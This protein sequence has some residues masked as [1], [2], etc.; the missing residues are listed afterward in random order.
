MCNKTIS[1]YQFMRYFPNEDIAIKYLEKRHWKDGVNCP[2]CCGNRIKKLRQKSYYL[3][4]DC[5]KKFTVRTGTIFARSH[6][7]LDKWLY[8]MY[9]VTTARK[10]VSSLQLSKELGITQKSSWFMLQRIREAC[11]DDS[12]LLNGI[13][14]ID[15]T[16]IGSR[17]RNKHIDKKTKGEQVRST[18]TKDPPALGMRERGGKIKARPFKDTTAQTL[19]DALQTNVAPAYCRTGYEQVFVNHSVKEFVNGIASTNGIESVWALLKQAHYGTHHQFNKKHLKRYG[20]E[21]SFSLNEGNVERHT[22][23][24]IDSLRNKVVGNQITYSELVS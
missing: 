14:E 3:C 15:E 9:C 8:A 7:P 16:Y 10:G 4:N 22:M 6:I 17:E 20:D 11:G 2:H 12:S 18:K 1:V 13:A 23:D 5:R 21:C 24:R 19:T